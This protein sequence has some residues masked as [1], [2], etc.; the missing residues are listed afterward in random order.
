MV[1]GVMARGSEQISL[2]WIGNAERVCRQCGVKITNL[3]KQVGE[4]RTRYGPT[5]HGTRELLCMT[6][7]LGKAERLV[8]RTRRE[9][10]LQDRQKSA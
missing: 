4:V 6:C 7:H 8:E 1:G 10:G 9:L 2:K 5:G 3:A